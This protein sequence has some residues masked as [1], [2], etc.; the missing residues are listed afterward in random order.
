MCQFP[1]SPRND[2]LFRVR[3]VW[4][5]GDVLQQVTVGIVTRIRLRT[6]EALLSAVDDGV[7]DEE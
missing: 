5:H 7:H 6:P 1:F 2:A 3:R 4:E